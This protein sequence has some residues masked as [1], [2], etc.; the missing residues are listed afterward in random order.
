MIQGTS[1]DITKAAAISFRKWV[2]DNKLEEEVFI[3]N[4]IH[5]EINCEASTLLSTRVA[6]NLQ[7]CMEDAAKTW[8]KDIELKADAQIKDYWT[9]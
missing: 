6:D 3:T 4:I 5:D 7:K 1:G 2:Y 9:H 8:C